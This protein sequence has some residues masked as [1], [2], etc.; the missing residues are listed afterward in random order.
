MKQRIKRIFPAAAA[1]LLTLGLFCGA[2]YPAPTR[3]FFVND[4][5]NVLS[6]STKDYIMDRSAS[7]D[8]QT[9]AQL[10]VL[11][12][13]SLDGQDRDSYALGVARAWGIGSKEKNNGVLLLLAPDDGEIKVEVG[14]GLE[15]ALNDAKVGR[16]ID[17]YAIS[18]YKEGDFDTG[19]REL[20]NGLLSEILVEYGLDALPGYEAIPEESEESDF[21]DLLVILVVILVFVSI[22]SRG[23]RGRN[24]RKG[25]W[26]D[27]DDDHHFGGPFFFGGFGGFGRGGGGGFGGGGFSG[28]GGSFGG[29]GSGRSF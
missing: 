19:T 5:A 24:R 6:Q 7:L 22:F 13:A 28:G 4:Y 10:V 14:R 2:S 27:D 9:G 16:L 3:D 18:S 29:G 12:V 8:Q 17:T 21:G 15:G 1:L 20:Y 11:T 23:R 26:D 25:P